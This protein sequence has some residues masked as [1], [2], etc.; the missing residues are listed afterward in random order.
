MK[1][2]K[3]RFNQ[4]LADQIIEWINKTSKMQ[5]G[6]IGITRNDQTRD[7]FCVTWAER[8][9]ISQ[10]TRYL[11]NL[12]D[13]EEETTFTRSDNLHSQ[14]KG[15]ADDMKKLM[16]QLTRLYVFRVNT[17]LREE[18]G[19]MNSIG[20]VIRTLV[21]LYSAPTNL[22]SDIVRAEKRGKLP[23]R[24]LTCLISIA[25]EILLLCTKQPCLPNTMYRRLSKPTGSF[26]S[27]YSML[28]PRVEQGVF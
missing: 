12:E 6:I 26:C 24:F 27:D 20:D 16:K 22:V 19:D 14:M 23:W 5:N 4:V 13:E 18:D 15:D 1:R 17:A 25:R 11:F 10:D 9:R 28:S 3:R 8:S 21:S 2:T 7:K